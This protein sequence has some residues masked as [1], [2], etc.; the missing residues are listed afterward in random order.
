MSEPQFLTDTAPAFYLRSSIRGGADG[1]NVARIEFLLNAHDPEVL[2]LLPVGVQKAY[3][4]IEDR[5]EVT[6]MD[7]DLEYEEQTVE[8]SPYPVGPAKIRQTSCRLLSFSLKR[9]K[10]EQNF[11]VRLHFKLDIEGDKR[12]GVWLW[13]NRGE[14]V[15]LTLKATQSHLPELGPEK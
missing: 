1:R 5:P 10:I 13:E 3:R 6:S 4:A 14:T 12:L 15:L 2:G 11:T 9:K 8:L 7:L